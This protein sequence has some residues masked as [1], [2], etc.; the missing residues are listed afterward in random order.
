MKVGD[1]VGAIS[2]HDDQ[3]IYFFG[4][5]VYQGEEVPPP[6]VKFMGVPMTHKNPKIVLDNGKAVWGCE[7]W[8]G[9]EENINKQL[10]MSKKT[11][12]LVDIE[13]ARKDVEEARAMENCV[14]EDEE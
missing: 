1:R 4:Y 14:D 9:P 12:V 13:K 2:H 6:E 11:I 10:E 5:G 7:C 8:W 3:N